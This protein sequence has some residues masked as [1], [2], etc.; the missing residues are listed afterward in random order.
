MARGFF[1][2]D[3]RGT[4]AFLKG[5]AKVLNVKGYSKLKPKE[6]LERVTLVEKQAIPKHWFSRW[7]DS[8]RVVD[9]MQVAD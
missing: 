8:L 7:K 4:M 9:L 1:R 5:K 3:Q 6:L 2:Y